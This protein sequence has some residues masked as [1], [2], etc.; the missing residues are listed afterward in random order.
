MQRLAEL[1][2][3]GCAVTAAGATAVQPDLTIVDEGGAT[4]DRFGT[5]I[6]HGGGFTAFG[7]PQADTPSLSGGRVSIRHPLW[8]GDEDDPWQVESGVWETLEHADA[9]QGALFGQSLA[10]LDQ[11]LAV[12][13]PG[14]RLTEDIST[15]VG[16][17]FMYDV[18]QSPIGTA[19]LEQTISPAGLSQY[20]EFGHSVALASGTGD[21]RWLAV[22]APGRDGDR[23]GVWLF[24]TESDP[25]TW[26]FQTT[27][28]P[29]ATTAGDRFGEAVAMHDGLL[30]VGAP[31]AQDGLGAAYVYALS[32]ATGQ[33][34]IV[35][36]VISDDPNLDSGFGAAVSVHGDDLV[37][38]G[39]G[40]AGHASLWRYISTAGIVVEEAVLEPDDWTD[41]E[42][43]GRSVSV[44]PPRLLVGGS[45]D[46]AGAGT[47]GFFRQID[48]LDFQRVA[49]LA[50][51]D[52]G[53]DPRH[54]TSVLLHGDQAWVGA[55]RA[56]VDAATS[57]AVGRWEVLRTPGCPGDLDFDHDA[58][59]DDIMAIMN[60]WG[61]GD[62]GDLTGDGASD[63]Q[64]LLM[65]LTH[66]GPCT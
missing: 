49:M 52:W 58:D 7:S 24:S 34:G 61:A 25:D 26:A 62:D 59:P 13:S 56:H 38:G 3:L 29:A 37:I 9:A 39:P 44:E 54:G 28:Q 12:G 14:W 21:T 41:V 50:E 53:F 42:G 30:V 65:V 27:V 48:T 64:D 45:P 11:T 47:A 2:I 33:W 55:P 5:A 63:V 51:G 60:D 10:A 19:T 1:L 16:G 23:G 17:V 43:W 46:T 15:K 18:T 32:Q 4:G 57:G 22:G 40:A 8:L 36:E 66:W 35:A 20:D 6:A 31:D